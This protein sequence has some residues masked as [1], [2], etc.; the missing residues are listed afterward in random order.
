ME[1][2]LKCNVKMSQSYVQNKLRTK[3]SGL[4]VSLALHFPYYRRFLFPEPPWKPLP[5]KGFTID[6]FEA[7][8]N[9]LV[10]VVSNNG[11]R[12]SKRNKSMKE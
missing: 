8:L 10:V 7:S 12:A 5:S 2:H 1:K 9:E 3:Q 6:R 4:P 11:G